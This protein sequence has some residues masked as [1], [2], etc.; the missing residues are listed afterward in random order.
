MGAPTVERLA[1]KRI[2]RNAAKCK[3][4]GDVLESTLVS[5]FLEC[6]CGAMVIGGGKTRLSR[7]GDMLSIEELSE[8]VDELNGVPAG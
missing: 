5:D 2:I 7:A 1:M 8:T 6:A 3:L 4:C